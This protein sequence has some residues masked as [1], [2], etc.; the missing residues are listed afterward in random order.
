MTGNPV[1]PVTEKPFWQGLA[2]AL[3]GKEEP[4]SWS[5]A[6]VHS[7]G[8]SPVEVDMLDRKEISGLHSTLGVCVCVRTHVHACMRACVC[9]V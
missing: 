7:V 8:I 6:A 5:C 2:M 9:V 4:V 3:L 1:N